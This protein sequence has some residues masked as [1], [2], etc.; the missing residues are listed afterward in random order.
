MEN[1]P[2][3]LVLDIKDMALQESFIDDATGEVVIATV[4]DGSEYTKVLNYDE[5]IAVLDLKG[6][7]YQLNNFE[8]EAVEPDVV[9]DKPPM[10]KLDW[11]ELAVS[12]GIPAESA[13]RSINAFIKNNEHLKHLQ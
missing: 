5:I 3:Q 4:F 13:E 12:G 9:Y 1:F 7:P 11:V 8:Q 2:N 6:Q 10:T